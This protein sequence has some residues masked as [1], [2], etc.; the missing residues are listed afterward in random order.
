MAQPRQALVR[1][2]SQTN[3]TTT[4]V[5]KDVRSLREVTLAANT[6]IYPI[7][8]KVGD[9]YAPHALYRTKNKSSAVHDFNSSFVPQNLHLPL[10]FSRKLSEI[11]LQDVLSIRLR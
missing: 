11:L 5:I 8:V 4:H 9:K 10:S 1:E 6:N 7:T 3:N 2:R